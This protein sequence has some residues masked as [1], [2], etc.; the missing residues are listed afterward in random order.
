MASRGL[1]WPRVASWLH[2]GRELHISIGRV[3]SSLG[4]LGS[5]VGLARGARQGEDEP[6]N[7][8]V[9]RP[10]YIAQRALPLIPAC[11]R[12][13][14]DSLGRGSVEILIGPTPSLSALPRPH[15]QI[16]SQSPRTTRLLPLGLHIRFPPLNI[17]LGRS[18]GQWCRYLMRFAAVAQGSLQRRG[19]ADWLRSGLV[20][21]APWVK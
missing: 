4:G 9:P 21:A 6:W 10:G 14:G 16:F 1:P 3:F 12:I 17:A 20:I 5:L 7:Y 18:S 2:E 19:Q 15:Y 11:S 13:A 8:Q